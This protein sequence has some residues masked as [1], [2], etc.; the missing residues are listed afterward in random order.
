M[1]RV[2]VYIATTEG[3]VEIQRLAK[4]DPEVR[5]VIC[6]NG[7]CEALSISPGYDAF[8]RKPTGIIERLFGHPVYRMDVSKRIGEGRSWQLG[9]LAAHALKAQGKLA[10]KD[11]QLNHI[12]WITGEIDNELKVHPVQHVPEK[13]QQSGWLFKEARRL[14]QPLTLIVPAANRES[15]GDDQLPKGIEILAIE[16]VAE[17]FQLL[18][19]ELS[20]KGAK[21]SSVRQAA[22]NSATEPSTSKEP[23]QT[24]MLTGGLATAI[25]IAVSGILL[26]ESGQNDSRHFNETEVEPVTMA[27]DVV[28][29]ELTLYELRAPQGSNCAAVRFGKLDPKQIEIAPTASQNYRSERLDKLCGLTYR[30]VSPDKNT[31]LNIKTRFIRG[32]RYFENSQLFAH[33]PQIQQGPEVNWRVI[34]PRR[35][36]QGFEYEITVLVDSKELRPIL[37]LGD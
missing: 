19:L 17:L 23:K 32:D 1:N 10:G 16:N 14:Q 15:I 7:T 30:L 13:L 33:A 22:K 5:S 11:D 12:L 18:G 3:P 35:F 31:Q 28:T 8:V 25:V 20:S 36:R 29:P 26:H 34:F 37:H 21:A 24:S 4:E 27:A 9:A 2:R 6:L